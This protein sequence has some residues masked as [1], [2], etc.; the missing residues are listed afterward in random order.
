M[1]VKESTLR[2]IIRE[3]ARRALREAD[4]YTIPITT[5]PMGN[6]DTGPVTTT[7]KDDE[8]TYSYNPGNGQMFIV[9]GPET[10]APTQVT[11][12]SNPK[13]YYAILN[14]YQAKMGLPK[15]A[16]AP[17]AAAAAA[18]AGLSDE[19]EIFNMI[20][21]TMSRYNLQIQSCYNNRTK[22]LPDLKGTWNLL[23]TV[24]KD[25]SVKNVKATPAQGTTPDPTLEA[26]MTKSIASWKF[27]AIAYEQPVTKTVR[28]YP[29]G[30]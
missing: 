27:A 15:T 23:F 17:A 12:A 24:N 7:W 8:Y 11:K 3:E 29:G 6:A 21:E 19:N 18:P 4:D 13:A 14:Q 2:R 10:T 16:P 26:C 20:K 28:L 22:Q 9:S 5:A 1:L 30:Y 25:G